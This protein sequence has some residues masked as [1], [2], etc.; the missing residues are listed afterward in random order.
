MYDCTPHLAYFVDKFTGKERDAESGLDM[1]GARYYGSNVGRFATP[2]WAV[3]PVT[4]PYA[5]SGNPQSLNLYVYVEN[6]PLYKPDLDGHGCPPYC[7]TGG[8]VLDFLDGAANAF[9]SDN[10]LGAGR[11]NE[12]TASGKIGAAVG[13]FAA[14]FQ[15]GAETLFGGGVEVGGVALDATG[16]GAVVGVPAN[17]V[18]AGLILHRRKHYRRGVHALV[19]QYDRSI[20]S[21]TFGAPTHRARDGDSRA[22]PEAPFLL[23]MEHRKKGMSVACDYGAVPIVLIPVY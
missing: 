3:K 11:V 9:G 19:Q 23:S 15:G 16:V 8:P 10:L 7:G 14:T 6:N 12:T 2:D 4:V 21:V 1:F 5:N 13:D 20:E 22:T 18:G 17:V